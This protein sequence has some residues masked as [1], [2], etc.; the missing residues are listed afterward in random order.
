MKISTDFTID[1]YFWAIIP[2]VNINLHTKSLEIEWLCFGFYLDVCKKLNLVVPEQEIVNDIL[3]NATEIPAKKNIA[4]VI[5]EYYI[6]KK[7]K[8]N[9]VK[10]IAVS[11]DKSGDLYNDV[12]LIW[13][14]ISNK[15]IIL[16]NHTE[17]AL[18]IKYLLK[19]Y[20]KIEYHAENYT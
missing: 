12:L 7:W 14:V 20:Q 18:T 6:D 4:P 9:I 19:N 11:D 1:P 5:G 13:A 10:V 2:A 16:K 17:F 15:N 3:S 8:R